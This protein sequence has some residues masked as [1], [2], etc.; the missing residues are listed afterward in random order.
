MPA[1]GRPYSLSAG[2]ILAVI[3]LRREPG[4]T[5]SF[6]PILR[7]MRKP[8]VSMRLSDGTRSFMMLANELRHPCGTCGSL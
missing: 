8:Q 3:G 5:R 7:R 4:G 2:F 1:W 6:N